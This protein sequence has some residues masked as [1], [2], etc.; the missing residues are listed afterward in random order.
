MTYI[1]GGAYK[2]KILELLKLREHRSTI[3]HSVAYYDF[4]E[5]SMF[6]VNRGRNEIAPSMIDD[7]TSFY[8]VCY[9][10]S[11][12]YKGNIQPASKFIGQW[13]SDYSEFHLWMKGSLD[14]D[15]IHR[16]Q[17]EEDTEETWDLSLL[18]KH[19]IR[20]GV[21]ANIKGRFSCVF[22]DGQDIYLFRNEFEPMF[23]DKDLT[24]CTIPFQGSES[25]PP[26][27]ILRMDFK[28][29]QLVPT[30]QFSTVKDWI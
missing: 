23:Y 5:E 17:V 30:N 16:I 15:T 7:D 20:Y 29:S 11:S 2:N 6:G 28:K 25:T 10:D 1:I 14:P 22:C 9:L 8:Y 27:K 4:E 26:N 19:V 3:S 18:L 24:I 21:P 12:I 13:Q